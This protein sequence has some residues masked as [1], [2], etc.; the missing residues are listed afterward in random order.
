MSNLRSLTYFIRIF[1]YRSDINHLISQLPFD[2]QLVK[3]QYYG[4]ALLLPEKALM[5]D[6]GSSGLGH[7]SVACYG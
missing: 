7:R 4:L 6:C 5:H 2:Y 3:N 1:G